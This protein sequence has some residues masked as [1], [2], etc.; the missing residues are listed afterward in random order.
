VATPDTLYFGFGFEGISTP[1]ARNAVM[2]R[3]MAYL[4][5]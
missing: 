1:S 3:S 5:R 4:L 2:A